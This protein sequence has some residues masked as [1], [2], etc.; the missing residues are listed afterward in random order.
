MFCPNCGTSNQIANSYCR[1]CGEFLTSAE[2]NNL[3][4]FGRNSPEKNVRTFTYVSLTGGLLSLFAALWMFASHFNVP[5]VLYFGLA[6][7]LGNAV[8]HSINF[9]SGIKFRMHL[10]KAKR[11]LTEA[12]TRSMPLSEKREPIAID[13]GEQSALTSVTENTTRQLGEKVSN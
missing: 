5:F 8:W 2:G 9:V 13:A 11:E 1:G 7:L 12:A 4:P 10:N 6:I 3:V